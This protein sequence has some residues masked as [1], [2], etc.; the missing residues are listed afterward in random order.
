MPRCVVEIYADEPVP[1]LLS[2]VVALATSL[3]PR[4]RP[5]LVRTRYRKSELGPYLA[6]WPTTPPDAD[7]SL[8]AEAMTDVVLAEARVHSC[9][10]C[11]DE[12]QVLRPDPGYRFPGQGDAA[13][14]MHNGCP[15]CGADFSKSRL[16]GL[17]MLPI[18]RS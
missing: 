17:L 6:V 13:H 2:P 5:A 9:F 8:T 10:V 3:G 16:Q 12:F 1:D 14:E 18:A 7:A 11:H 4:Y 15:N